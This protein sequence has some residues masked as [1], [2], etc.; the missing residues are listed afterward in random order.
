LDRSDVWRQITT[1]ELRLHRFRYPVGRSRLC[2]RQPD[3]RD[4]KKDGKSK[5]SDA[6]APLHTISGFAGSVERTMH[7]CLHRADVPG[8]G[9][10]QGRQEQ[11]E[12]LHSR[13]GQRPLDR[14][15]NPHRRRIKCGTF[16]GTRF[17]RRR[18]RNP[19]RPAFRAVGGRVQQWPRVQGEPSGGLPRHAA[20]C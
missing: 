10:A 11:C 4:H 19:P 8:R 12:L 18:C 7:S 13:R 17:N 1:S 6:P 2:D 16:A 14:R 5:K 9:L 20:A 3:E 15:G